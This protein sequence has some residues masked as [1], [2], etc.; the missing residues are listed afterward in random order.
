MT[1]PIRGVCRT[2]AADG[3]EVANLT[4]EGLQVAGQNPTRSS[5][6]TNLRKVS[7][8]TDNGLSAGPIDLKPFGQAPAEL[9][10][11]LVSVREQEVRP[12]SPAEGKPI[13]GKEVPGSGN[14]RNRTALPLIVHRAGGQATD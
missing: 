13:C 14:R 2:W 11:Y 4:I 12:R 10:R 9:C 1:R 5:L 6:I 3:W 8:W 7:D